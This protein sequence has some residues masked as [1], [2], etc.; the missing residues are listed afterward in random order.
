MKLS[1]VQSSILLALGLQRK[2]IEE[3]E[4]CC[5][6]TSTVAAHRYPSQAELSVPV[7]QALALFV[8]VVRKISNKLTEIQKAAISAEMPV[9]SISRPG[10]SGDMVASDWKPVDTNL[11]DELDKAGDEA[12]KVLREKQREMINS[13]DL[14]RCVSSD[15]A[16]QL[17]LLRLSGMP[18]MI[19]PKTGLP[20]RSKSLL[21]LRVEK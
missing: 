11:E 7:S 10:D 14:S 19:H 15:S 9:P 5:S 4:V 13:L 20:L 2:T 3:V 21:S 6:D 1:A 8:K 17:R 16:P 18:L 12:T